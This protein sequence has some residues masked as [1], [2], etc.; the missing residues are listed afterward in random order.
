[1]QTF[2]CLAPDFRAIVENQ[3]E[4]LR[5]LTFEELTKLPKATEESL[6]SGSRRAKLVIQIDAQPDGS[7]RVLVRAFAEAKSFVSQS[8]FSGFY[9]HADGTTTALT[10]G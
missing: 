4:A 1:M 9:K 2:P 3:C 8:S 7:L 5:K 6:N 10:P